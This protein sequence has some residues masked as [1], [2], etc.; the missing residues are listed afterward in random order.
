[1]RDLAVCISY[2]S[3]DN[4]PFK[5]VEAAK[6]AGFK[7]VF[8]QWYDESGW[9]PDQ[10]KQLDY[11]KQSGL[12]VIFAHLGY[13]KI[14]SIWEEGEPGDQLT[15]RFCRDLDDL[16]R[17][18]V[19]EVM[20]HPSSKFTA[21]GPNEIGLAR[22]RKIVDHARELG[23]KAAFENTKIKGYLDYIA[24]NIPDDNL[25]I[26]VD[27]GHAHCHF[28]DDLD[29]DLFTDRIFSVHLHDNHGDDKDE[30]LLPFDGT[31]DWEK[32]IGNLVKAHYDGP[33]TLEVIHS[34][35]YADMSIDEFFKEAYARGEKLAEM[36]EEAEKKL[37]N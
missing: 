34:A 10:Q 37:E 25:G 15:E 4:D 30:H 8:I 9:D 13:Q 24:K 11:I 3:I 20:L 31:I 32:I 16:H 35:A 22:I 14:N 5:T 36:F 23:M 7:K 19:N 6:R 17:N 12:E 1:M 21:P 2:S 18:G 26:C 33:V 28:D 27:V 29:Y